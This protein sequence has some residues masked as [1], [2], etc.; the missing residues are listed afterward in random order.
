MVTLLI[1]V[2]GWH[3][4]ASG[5]RESQASAL[6]FNQPLVSEEPFLTDART[7]CWKPLL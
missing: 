7:P 4:P 6:I 2:L 5:T 1:K 3:N